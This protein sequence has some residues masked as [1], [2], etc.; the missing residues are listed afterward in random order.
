MKRKITITGF[1]ATLMA[2]AIFIGYH[3]L[4]QGSFSAIPIPLNASVLTATATSEFSD[5]SDSPYK[6]SIENLKN[7]G[8]ISGY[9]DGS[10]KPKNN[11][12]RA[13]LMKFLVIAKGLNPDSYIYNSCFPDVKQEWFALYV[14]YSKSMG[15][16]K[17][18]PDGT[19]RAGQT[20]KYSEAIKMILEV[21]GFNP[22]ETT[23]PWYQAYL[24]E[25]DKLGIGLDG[26]GPD[27]NLN[28][29][30][31]AE[32]IV[33]AMNVNGNSNPTVN[34]N[35]NSETSGCSANQALPD[36]TCTPGDVLTMDTSVICKT[37]YTEAVRDVPI[38]LKEQVF[39]EY[40]ISYDLHSNYEVDHLISLELGGSND[41]SNLWPESYSIT[42]GA[43]IKDKLENYLHSQVCSGDM[44]I[45][46]AQ[47]EISGDWLKYYSLMDQSSENNDET[48]TLPSST[49][50]PSSTNDVTNT[51][52]PP[53][54]KSSSGICHAQGTTYYARTT[55][56]TS[57]N[58][59]D[60]CLNSGG[61]LPK[62]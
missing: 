51:N 13:E 40:G 2:I 32:L 17:G 3:S 54:K 23:D 15:W 48:V 5:I 61:R 49:Q 25:A 28:R 44:T 41:I 38:S 58:S 46:E 52:N 9:S 22:A 21:F 20:V 62:K 55:N 6:A 1:I 8:I 14:C 42:N 56:F 10:F 60:D 7:K 33:R 36:S 26:M 12:N 11:V 19:Y 35:P 27:I 50:A 45:S 30:Q 37:G 39:A 34:S 43:R 31:V 29:E 47:N 4:N 18:Y 57:Y 59:L 53:V 16:T 24:T